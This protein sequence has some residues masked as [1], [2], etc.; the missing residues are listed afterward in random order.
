MFL[1]ASHEELLY[2]NLTASP[3]PL[4]PHGMR[5]IPVRDLFILSR[6]PPSTPYTSLYSHT[7]YVFLTPWVPFFL[8]FVSSFVI[9]LLLFVVVVVVA[10]CVFLSYRQFCFPVNSALG[11]RLLHRHQCGRVQELQ[12]G[13][14]T[15][16]ARRRMSPFFSITLFDTSDGQIMIYLSTDRP[17]T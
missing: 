1:G 11:K 13:Q 9:F 8:L 14:R 15:H 2:I 17:S 16:Q 10:R 12:A 5:L 3:L 4:V 6:P 7:P